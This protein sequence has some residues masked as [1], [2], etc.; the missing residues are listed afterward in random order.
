MSSIQSSFAQNK[1]RSL[2]TVGT[3]SFVPDATLASLLTTATA[4]S[5][6]SVAVVP[7]TTAGITLFKTFTALAGK[8]SLAAGET[9]TDLGTETTV[10]ISGDFTAVV[11]FRRV[12]RSNGALTSGNPLDNAVTGFVVVENTV[13]E[14]AGVS[15]NAN[16]LVARV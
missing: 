9:L 2:V 5:V 12:K 3:A 4:V 8:T 6:G 11:K 1:S 10:E 15:A 16:V 7:G 13:S 14:A